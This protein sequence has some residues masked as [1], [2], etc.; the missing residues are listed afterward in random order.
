MRMYK[1]GR[2]RRYMNATQTHTRSYEGDPHMYIEKVRKWASE[3]ESNEMMRALHTLNENAWNSTVVAYKHNQ[4]KKRTLSL[5]LCV[6][7]VCVFFVCCVLFSPMCYS[8]M[9]FFW[10]VLS[11]PP[12]VRCRSYKVG[13][14]DS[15][16][17]SYVHV[18]LRTRG[19]AGDTHRNRITF[20]CIVRLLRPIPSVYVCAVHCILFIYI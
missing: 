4:E 19:R 13:S 12:F 1:I 2:K 10:F 7:Y 11:F 3:R 16:W 15:Y 5:S 14:S 20:Y 18:S 17:L 6:A 9:Q 8:G